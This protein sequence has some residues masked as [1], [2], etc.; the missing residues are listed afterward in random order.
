[1]KKRMIILTIILFC[2]CIKVN[3][4]IICNDGTE[5]ESCTDCHQGCCS[6]HDGC[7][8]EKNDNNNDYLKYIAIGTG[9]AV[10]SSASAY[11][12]FKTGSNKNKA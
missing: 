3:A 5:S 2:F 10:I 4:N 8:K 11:V 1:M 12:G 7:I 6:G 9:T